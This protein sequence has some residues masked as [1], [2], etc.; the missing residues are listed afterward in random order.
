MGAQLLNPS[1]AIL[2]IEECNGAFI[3]ASGTAFETGSVL[4]GTGVIYSNDVVTILFGLRDIAGGNTTNLV[5][6]LMATNGITNVVSAGNYGVLVENG[7]T[8][9]EPFTFTAVGTN[10]QHI[11]ATLALQDGTRELGTV[12]F[13][14]TIGG[15]TLSFTNS[16]PLTFAGVAPL[17]SRATNSFAPGFG[18][19]SLINVSGIVGTV[20][21]VTATLTN[22]GHTFPENMNVVLEAPQGQ[23][24]ILMSHCGGSVDVQ[25]ITF[26]FD[27]SAKVSMPTNSAITNGTYLP[28]ANK[29]PFAMTPLPAVPPG[30]VV[31]AAPQGPYTANLGVFT[32]AVPNGNWALWIDDDETLDSGYVSNGWILNISIGAQVENDSDLQLTLTPSTT[33][34]TLG[35]ALTYFVTLTNYGPSAATNVVVS[36]MIPSGMSYVTNTCNCGVFANGVLTFTYPSL[37]VG[38]GTSFG[39]VLLPTE[40][41]FAA[42]TVTALAN[43][44]DPN[45]NNIVT[46]TV[47]VS[48]PEADM[49]VSMTENPDPVLDGSPV[50]FTV[51]A[52]NNGPSIATGVVGT[53]TLPNGFFVTSI[54]PAASATNSNG[55][56]TWNV[57][58]LGT[59]PV[60]ST[61]TLT[62]VATTTV[63]GTGLATAS[64]TS[65]IYDPTKVNNFA[66]VKTEVDQPVI[67]VSVVGQSYTL[68]WPATASN[69]VLEGAFNLPPAGTWVPITPSPPLVSGQYSFTLPG[70]NGYQF[71][72]LATQTP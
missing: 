5:A 44:P 30:E 13:G 60:T 29:V 66:S 62:V 33:N 27:Q 39:I 50:T 14:L 25:H 59:D 53:I 31:P 72:R 16:E 57:G 48:S 47:L 18:Y 70:A 52:T 45:S 28:T 64:V 15:A 23:N 41:G 67:S 9:A 56:I 19:P 8:K 21:E 17:P 1:A 55:T 40:L 2:T 11:T 43:E 65:A 49:G 38:A 58:T 36:N 10:G 32:G 24:S 42:N 35:N 37:A 46:S 51:V 69:F 22:F 61:A 34:A 6:T 63:G 71:F 3:V 20:T 12:A 26:T 68:T 7:P 4:P 54:T